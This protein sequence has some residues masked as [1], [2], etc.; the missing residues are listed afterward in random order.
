MKKTIVEKMNI[1][2]EVQIALCGCA[3]VTLSLASN[4]LFEFAVRSRGATEPK[5]EFE[6]VAVNQDPEKAADAVLVPL[7]RTA[8]AKSAEL[9]RHPNLS[10]ERRKIFEVL[11][12]TIEGLVVG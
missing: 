5:G 7:V 6:F 8:R 1:A 10:L 12:R 11:D 9:L 4:G 2:R 3:F